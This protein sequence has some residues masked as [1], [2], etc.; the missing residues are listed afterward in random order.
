M[1]TRMRPPFHHADPDAEQ[2]EANRVTASLAGLAAALLF[3]VVGL[4]LIHHL[5]DEARI[6]DCLMSGRYACDQ[7]IPH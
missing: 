7:L 3:V 4:L 1:P 2:A 6:E 5:H